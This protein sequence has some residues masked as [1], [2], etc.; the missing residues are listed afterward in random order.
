MNSY[1]KNST[2]VMK[3]LTMEVFLFTQEVIWTVSW[4]K[5]QVIITPIGQNLK[6][7]QNNKYFLGETKGQKQHGI[8]TNRGHT[9]SP[10]TEVKDTHMQNA[11][12]T[13]TFLRKALSNN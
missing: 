4:R 12:S 13:F 7:W 10:T 6:R 1:D 11:R 5:P 8:G 9:I 2:S 3:K